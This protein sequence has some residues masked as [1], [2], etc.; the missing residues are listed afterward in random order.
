MVL[1]KVVVFTPSAFYFNLH[2]PK[3]GL[4]LF[5]KQYFPADNLIG[6]KHISEI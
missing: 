1:I 4:H 2:C 5:Y 6:Y 3:K